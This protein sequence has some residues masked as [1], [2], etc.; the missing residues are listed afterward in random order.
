LKTPTRDVLVNSESRSQTP[1]QKYTVR[2][3]D[4]LYLIAE[5]NNTTIEAL[6][7]ANNLSS[8]MLQPGQVLT[9]PEDAETLLAMTSAPELTHRVRRG[10]SLWEI[11]TKYGTSISRLRAMNGLSGDT[12]RIGQVLKV[13]GN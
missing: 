10:D 1:G 8:I 13:S 7:A 6:R 3:G 9:I 4:S 2:T 5:R 11:A 12:L